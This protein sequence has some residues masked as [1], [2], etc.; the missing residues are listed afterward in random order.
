M[1]KSKFKLV[2]GDAGALNQV[3]AVIPSDLAKKKDHTYVSVAEPL[4]QHIMREIDKGSI[5]RY[6]K[7]V[8]KPKQGDL[9]IEALDELAIRKNKEI[10]KFRQQINK[11]FLSM[12]L[13]D[14]YD[15][16]M[17]NNK[18][19][20]LGHFIHEGNKEEVYLAIIN[21]GDEQLVTDLE[22][23]LTAM[24][25]LNDINKRYKR[26]RDDIHRIVDAKDDAELDDII[27]S[28]GNL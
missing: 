1:A 24:E 21:S 23:Y 2:I 11:L 4:A 26:Y 9:V 27:N 3:K 12:N 13:M 18:F 19:N 15:F 16:M 20:S 28:L 14:M 7:T 25:E 6:P 5:I 8:G 22:N 17:I 10:A